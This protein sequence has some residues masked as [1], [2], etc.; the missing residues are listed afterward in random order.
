MSS[1]RWTRCGAGSSP[2]RRRSTS[3]PSCPQTAPRLTAADCLACAAGASPS[4]K[5]RES[6][7]PPLESPRTRRAEADKRLEVAVARLRARV[8]RPMRA[9]A[10]SPREREAIGRT[11]ASPGGRG[12]EGRGGTGAL[13]TAGIGEAQSGWGWLEGLRAERAAGA[14][15]RGRKPKRKEVQSSMESI[16]GLARQLVEGAYAASTQKVAKSAARAFL[17]FEQVARAHRPVP[18]LEPEYAG[19]LKAYLHNEMTLILWAAWMLDQGLAPGTIGSYVSLFKTSMAVSTGWAL[20][21][22]ESEVRLP[23]LM[24]AI[25]RTR[26]NLRRRRLGWRSAYMRR[27]RAAVGAPRGWEACTDDAVLNTLRQGLLRAA[28]V[29]PESAS[30]FDQTRHATVGDLEEILGERR[31]LRFMVQPAKKSEQHGKIDAVLL[32]VGDGVTDAYSSLRRMLAERRARAPGGVL[33]EDEPL[34]AHANGTSYTRSQV[35]CLFKSAAA[36]IGMESKDFGGHSCARSDRTRPS[37]PHALSLL[38]M[39]G[40]WLRAAPPP[41]V[42]TS[43]IGPYVATSDPM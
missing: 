34:F 17:D 11:P 19:D 13:P 16:M 38:S 5:R 10:A 12:G 1:T 42:A 40:G 6:G 23:R 7:Q 14:P 28:D 4:R 35:R 26:K 24:R 25:R 33:N 2:T 8:R 41:Y 31:H 27:L 43:V 30:D 9:A 15:Q 39:R 32:P 29:V 37:M 21:S 3:M 22:K 36:A 20:T 18:F